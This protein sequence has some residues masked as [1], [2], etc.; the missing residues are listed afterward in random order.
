MLFSMS[1]P[2]KKYKLVWSD[3]FSTEGL[4]DASKWTYDVGDGCPRICGWGNN[5]WQYYTEADIDNASVKDGKLTIEARPEKM[6]GKE[7]TS[8]RLLTRNRAS[9]KYGYFE[10][11]A[12][13][14]VGLGTWS[15]IWLL[16]EK[17][18]YGEWPGSGEI[19][20]LEHVGFAQDSIFG[21]VHTEAFNH[22]IGT[23]KGGGVG[24]IKPHEDYHLYAIN[25][26]PEKMDFLFD[27]K[28]YFTF[29]KEAM[30]N[31][32]QWP[33]DQPFHIILNLAVGGNLGGKMGVDAKAFPARFSID[34]VRVYQK[35]D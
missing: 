34:Y 9:W 32:K 24:K 26:T 10:M 33:F 4:P 30:A 28:I 29:Y 23:Q 13:T 19:D 27:G 21:T 22:M 8:A 16:P 15:A 12:K 31:S 11:R 25:W 14:P 20:L 1:K 35:K 2:P 6:G 18:T 7:Y 5:E 3:E 17:N